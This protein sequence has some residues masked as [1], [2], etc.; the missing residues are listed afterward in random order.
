MTRR[1]RRFGATALVAVGT[2]L[3]AACENDLTEINQNPNAP[4]SVPVNNVL[5]SG[6]RDVAQ[7]AG[8]RGAFGKWTMLYHAENWAQ[9]I[10]QPVYNDEDFYIPRAGIPDLIWDEMY[11]ALADLKEARRLAEEAGNDNI[12]AITEVMSVYGFMILTDYYDAIPYA[13]ALDLSPDG[14]NVFPA[15][16]DG[17]VIY[18]DLIARLEA[19]EDLFDPAALID[20]GDFDPIYQGDVSGW[21]LFANSLQLRLAMRIGDAAAFAAAWAEPRFADVADEADVE[22]AATQPGA[23]PVYEG[24]IYAGRQGD[25]RMSQ[26]LIDRL[27]AFADPRLPIV[28]DPAETDGVFRGM[29]NGWLPSEH[30]ETCGPGADEPCGASDFS[31]IGAYFLEPTTPSD[32]LSYAEVLFLGAEAAALGWI[33]DSPAALYDEAITAS[34]TSMGVAPGDITTYLALPTVDY[35]TGT[36]RGVDAIHV[37]KWIALFL[38]GPEAFSDL[39]RYGWDWTTDAATTGTD[40][41]P[42]ENSDIGPVFPSRLPYPT[43]EVLLNPDNYPGDRELTDPVWWMP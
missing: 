26:S 23:N 2:L 42:A 11:F 3:A 37:Q 24:I 14:G 31:T 7:N 29:R 10:G 32:L 18:P 1:A 34:M 39:R 19:A 43:D 9:H 33:G 4:E 12:V 30:P 27:A 13:E 21:E 38:S 35:A 17:S 20:F 41:V 16:Q 5:L 40:L 15:Y 36:Y 22:W 6:L 28:A 25:F 8:E